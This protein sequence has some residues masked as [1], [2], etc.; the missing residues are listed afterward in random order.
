MPRGRGGFKKVRR[1]G[2]RV[3][4]V[5][6]EREEGG[7]Q[8]LTLREPIMRQLIVRISKTPNKKLKIQCSP[9]IS[10]FGTYHATINFSNLKNTLIFISIDTPRIIFFE[11][12]KK[13][14]F[15]MKDVLSGGVFSPHDLVRA[16]HRRLQTP[17][18]EWTPPP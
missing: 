15:C 10:F 17:Q 16:P 9:R 1:M 14:K 8:T 4:P 2:V 13:T 3:G 6:G 11:N 12:Q 18:W 7:M 5:E